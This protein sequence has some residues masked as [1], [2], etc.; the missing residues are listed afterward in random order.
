MSGWRREGGVSLPLPL[1]HLGGVVP[2]PETRTVR[3]R[4]VTITC[5]VEEGGTSNEMRSE[6]A[7]HSY[8]FE[9]VD[10]HELQQF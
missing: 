6:R 4:S 5:R 7:S 10:V 8:R 2:R 1:H 3:Y 9:E